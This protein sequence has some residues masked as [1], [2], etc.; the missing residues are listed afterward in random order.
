MSA[1][2]RVAAVAVAVL[3][4]VVVVVVAM[5]VADGPFGLGP[6]ATPEPT[7]SASAEQTADP[8]SSAGPSRSPDDEETLAILAE[9][10]EQ[11]IAIRGLPS[12]GI[13]PPEILT[14]EEL[15]AELERIFDEDYPPEEREQDNAA[16]RALGLLGPDEDVAELQLQLLGDQV[17]GFYDDVERRMVVVSDAGLDANAKFTYAHEYA[18]ALQDAAF[19]LDSLEIDADGEDDR[20]LAR[21]A[22]VEGDATVVMLAWAF[23]HLTPEELTGIITGTEI[24]DTSG[25]PSWMVDQ[26][27]F[28]YDAGGLWVG[29][30]AGN[31]LTPDFAAVDEAWAAPPDTTEQVL[32]PGAWDPPE[33]AIP[34]EAVD[35]ASGLGS[36]WDEVETTTLGQAFIETMLRYH[37]VA[38]TA[39]ATAARGWGGDRVVITSGPD[40][41]FALAW[42]SAWDSAD[43]AAEFADAY[44]SI[45]GELPFPA[46]VTELPDGEILVAHASSEELLAQTLDAAE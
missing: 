9:I 15:V 1:M 7:G 29:T 45:V 33:P 40:G 10:E 32:E 36:G 6:T 21:S 20:A 42:R 34:V 11:V 25:I 13:G 28:P 38:S 31:P 19:D 17:L 4:L 27:A 18:H 22:L 44:E 12:A 26:L 8:T 43:D 5:T 30:L 2:Q 46:S 39:S 35:L 14:R 37:G 41:D 16:L 3:V 23:E 24:P